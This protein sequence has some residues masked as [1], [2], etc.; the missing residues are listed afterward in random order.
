[1]KINNNLNIKNLSTQQKQ[2]K[3][4]E[5]KKLSRVEEIKQQIKNGTYKVD[6]EE[7][8]KAMAKYLLS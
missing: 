7:T 2:P 4:I 5:N 6:I 3:K 8:A 1:M